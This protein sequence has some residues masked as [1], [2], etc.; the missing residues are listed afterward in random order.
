[1]MKAIKDD[2]NYFGGG[3]SLSKDTPMLM[4]ERKLNHV[5]LFNPSFYQEVE[6]VKIKDI[7]DNWLNKTNGQKILI[8][9]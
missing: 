8:N 7:F 1:M 5:L 6:G 2:I 4:G 9:F 3:I